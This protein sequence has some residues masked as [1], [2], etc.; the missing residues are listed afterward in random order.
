[1]PYFYKVP[2]LGALG[3]LPVRPDVATGNSWVGR[4]GIGPTYLI[5][6][7][8]PIALLPAL[9]EAE[10]LVE[11]DRHGVVHANAVNRWRAGP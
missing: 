5:R 3:A 10:L 9:S 1:M 6:T 11:C 7:E 8:S 2:K 4:P